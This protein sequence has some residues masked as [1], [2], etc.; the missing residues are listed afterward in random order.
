MEG[1][2]LSH[3]ELRNALER[4]YRCGNENFMELSGEFVEEI[5]RD[6]KSNP[7]NSPFS[8][9]STLN[10]GT[11]HYS[12]YATQNGVSQPLLGETTLWS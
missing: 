8:V 6:C 10:L 4:A 3:D 11:Q 7:G 5:M 1:V 12:Y 2:F 9:T